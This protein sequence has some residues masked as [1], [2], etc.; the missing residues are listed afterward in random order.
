MYDVRRIMV[1]AMRCRHSRGFGV[2][3]PWAYSFIRY[4]IN[5]HYPYYAYKSLEGL[6]VGQAWLSR[7]LSR[8][9]F[10]M[11]NHL[12]PRCVVNFGRRADVFSDYVKAGCRSSSVI[13]MDSLVNGGAHEDRLADFPL[14]DFARFEPC[15]GCK[16]AYM[17]ALARVG[18]GSMFVVE[19]IHT[20]RLGRELWAEVMRDGRTGITFDLF[21]CGIVCFDK[22]RYRQNYI[23][24]F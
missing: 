11:S 14:I 6:H 16:E 5:E 13:S 20:S 21:Y 8:L 17:A 15:A 3:S 10:R 9:Y 23:V 24:N 18:A 4:V 7:K 19:G 22:K 12:Q 1:W 2:Q